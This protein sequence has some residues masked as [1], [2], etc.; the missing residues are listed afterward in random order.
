M[1]LP[2]PAT[3]R[4]GAVGRAVLSSCALAWNIVSCRMADPAIRTGSPDPSPSSSGTY[5]AMRVAGRPPRNSQTTRSKCLWDEARTPTRSGTAGAAER[6]VAEGGA[7][8]VG[9]RAALVTA[10]VP[11]EMVA[12]RQATR[13]ALTVRTMSPKGLTEGGVPT[14]VTRSAAAPQ[15]SIDTYD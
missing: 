9:T 11:S 5:W 15:L 6:A 3:T 7:S 13:V 1:T 10:P 2:S 12:T 8:V 4:P 14:R